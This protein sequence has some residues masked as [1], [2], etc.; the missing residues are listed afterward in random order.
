MKRVSILGTIALTVLCAGLFYNSRS[1]ASPIAT[2]APF[3]SG[4]LV[5]YRVG[6]GTGS[7]AS[8]AT[9]VFLDEYTPTGT[10]VQSIP[11][12]TAVNGANKRLTASG[13]ATSE[14]LMTRSTDGNYLVFTGY[15]A[16]LGTASIT[17]SA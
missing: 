7:L 10:L 11:A 6:T 8:S 14:G 13:T 9:A 12:P 4:N 1:S 5:I 3:T 15:D 2:A 17:G 16:D